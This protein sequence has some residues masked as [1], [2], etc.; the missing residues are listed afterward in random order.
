ML[1]PGGLCD[2]GERRRDFAFRPLTGEVELALAESAALDVDLPTSVS[3][4]LAAALAE[5]AGEAPTPEAVDALAV[6]DRQ[7]LIRQLAARL[8]RDGIWLTAACGHCGEPFDFF[9]EQSALPVKEAG[10]SFP[11]A[12]VQTSLGRCELRVPTGADQR[13]I[14]AI[15]D[16]ERALATLARRCLIS[17]EGASREQLADLQLSRDDLAA[18]SEALEAAAPEVTTCL[19]ASCPRCAEISE[20][21]LDPYLCMRGVDGELFEEIHLLASTYHW[22]E[23]EILAL[24][25]HRRQRY[26]RRIDHARGM[27]V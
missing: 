19:R 7:F 14:A 9:V 26:L 13:A 1:L 18:V 5:L 8:G 16:E 27:S 11:H 24:P 2:G 23:A 17:A 10:E 4:A 21:T 12:S 25:R 3:R 20:V 6:G 22:N 15:D